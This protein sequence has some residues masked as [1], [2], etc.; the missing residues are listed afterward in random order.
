MDPS[1]PYRA[2]SSSTEA[3]KT[4]GRG[5]TRY[6]LATLAIAQLIVWLLSYQNLLD[7]VRTG[8]ISPLSLLA[9][10]LSAASLVIAGLLVAG[11]W[12]LSLWLYATASLFAAAVVA[13]VPV[14][15]VKTALLIAVISTLIVW[16]LPWLR[17][18]AA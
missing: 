6:L 16:L 10:A 5:A 11:G 8:T 12:R 2:P 3:T 15:A 4:H 14:P 9:C 7:L 13:S 1:D 17:R 18:G